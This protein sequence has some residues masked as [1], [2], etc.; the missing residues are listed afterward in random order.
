MEA[1]RY[2]YR[3][4]E[5]LFMETEQASLA[6]FGYRESFQLES[7]QSAYKAKQF[8]SQLP[9]ASGSGSFWRTEAFKMMKEG[10]LMSDGNRYSESS[11]ILG[12]MIKCGLELNDVLELFD[13]YA[14]YGDSFT[15]ESVERRFYDW[16]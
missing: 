12:A 7:E 13:K 10:V 6:L 16:C 11:K 4:K 15:R 1:S 14:A 9:Y 5:Q 2:F 8:K 3:H